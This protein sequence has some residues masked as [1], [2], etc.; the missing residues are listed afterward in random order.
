MG[1]GSGFIFRQVQQ[2]G[3]DPD[4]VFDKNLYSYRIR[5]RLAIFDKEPYLTRV[6]IRSTPA[7]G[8]GS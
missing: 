7:E 1:T 3:M 5:I 2:E 8:S 4:P 6:R